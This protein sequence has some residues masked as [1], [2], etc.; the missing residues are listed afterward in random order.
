MQ[1]KTNLPG[2]LLI[3][4]RPENE[5]E[6]VPFFEQEED[7]WHVMVQP[8]TVIDGNQKEV[9]P[10]RKPPDKSTKWY[11]IVA[12]SPMLPRAFMCWKRRIMDGHWWKPKIPPMVPIALPGAD[13]R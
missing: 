10:L 12:K 11:N 13:M 2:T 5:A 3:R 7:I 1:V 9:Y 4:I 6:W 8:M